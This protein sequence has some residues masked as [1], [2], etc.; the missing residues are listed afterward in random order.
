M[1][2]L[3]AISCR[4]PARLSLSLAALAARSTPGHSAR[5]G[6]GVAY[7]Q[8]GKVLA[9][10]DAV[11]AADS[12]LVRQLA[13]E[14][15]PTALALSHIRHATRGA[16]TLA[17][18]QPFVRELHGR[19]HVFAHNGDLPG[20]PP[21]TSFASTPFCPQGD[22]DSESAFCMLLTQLEPLWRR[23][24]PSLQERLE[25]VHT[26]AAMLRPLGPANFLYADGELL[27]AHGHRRLQADGRLAPP[28]LHWL[29]RRCAR[30]SEAPHA[31]GVRLSH[32]YQQVVLLASVPLSDETWQPLDEGEVLAVA[33]GEVL[34]RRP[35]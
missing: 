29:Q 21:A 1:C 31:D 26:F 13:E 11:P 18:T 8:G 34:A 30:E 23:G 25:V 9:Y 14:G 22:T 6:W 32:G 10:R 35:P 2:E 27:F 17:N 15:P 5:D 19:S 33:G 3:L 7:F 12:P 16:R 4:Q 20:L 24:A 28:G